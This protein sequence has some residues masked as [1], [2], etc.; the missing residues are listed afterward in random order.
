MAARSE[1][2]QEIARW[3][4]GVDKKLDV[5]FEKIDEG[6]ADATKHREGLREVMAAL[7]LAIRDLANEVAMQKP[8]AA[9]HIE[10]RATVA[11]QGAALLE[12]T[13][14]VAEMQPDVRDYREKRAEARGAF[15]AA[16]L[17]RYLIGTIVAA[18]VFAAGYLIRIRGADAP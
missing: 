14:A 18:V 11:A 12:L 10:L 6:A 8:I 7:S 5:L 9:G 17:V 4:D 2:Q 16:M 15:Q 3:R 1:A 13:K